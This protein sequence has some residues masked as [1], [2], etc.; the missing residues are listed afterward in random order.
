MRK[1]LVLVIT[2]KEITVQKGYI[3][4]PRGQ[5]AKKWIILYQNACRLVL[6]SIL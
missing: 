2:N 4:P 5:T 1:V 6:G 3:T